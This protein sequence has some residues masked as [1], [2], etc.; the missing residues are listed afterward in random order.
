[1]AAP[2][3]D[4]FGDQQPDAPKPAVTKAFHKKRSAYNLGTTDR[5]KESGILI[6][7]VRPYEVIRISPLT[8]WILHK[9]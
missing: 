9:D 8:T 2:T 6:G 7:R 5:F 4:L 3:S 1:M